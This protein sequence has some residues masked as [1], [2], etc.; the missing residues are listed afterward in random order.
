MFDEKSKRLIII[1]DHGS[2][3][4][5]PGTTINQFTISELHIYHAIVLN[6]SDLNHYSSRDHIEHQLLSRTTFH[7]CT[8]CY[9]LR[10]DYH[11]NGI[12]D[13]PCQLTAIITSDAAGNYSILPGVFYSANHIRCSA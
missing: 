9:K 8:A 13:T 11:F 10:A 6:P 1:L 2:I 5:H 4:H 12:I 7:S 3:H